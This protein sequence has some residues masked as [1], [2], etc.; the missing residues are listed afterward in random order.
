[1][2]VAIGAFSHESHSFSKDTVNIEAMKQ[3][4]LTIKKH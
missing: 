3:V 2:R 4:I 1:M